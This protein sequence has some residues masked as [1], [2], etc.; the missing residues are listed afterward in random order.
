MK[1]DNWVEML[2]VWTSR[3]QP[4]VEVTFKGFPSD[5]RTYKLNLTGYT[6]LVGIELSKI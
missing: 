3:W 5:D 1:I 6:L 4:L 2:E